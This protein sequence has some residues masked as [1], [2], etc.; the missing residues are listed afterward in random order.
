MV[1]GTRNEDLLGIVINGCVKQCN[2]IGFPTII[3]FVS[4][5]KKVMVFTFIAWLASTSIMSPD[6]ILFYPRKTSYMYVL[7]A[8]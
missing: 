5:M 6:T 1:P 4:V 2:W 3:V 8:L 7:Q